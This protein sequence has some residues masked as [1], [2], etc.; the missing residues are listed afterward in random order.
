MISFCHTKKMRFVGLGMY[1]I[2][3][4]KKM[5]G[6]FDRNKEILAS[7]LYV[8]CDDILGFLFSLECVFVF[9]LFVVVVLVF[10]CLVII[11]AWIYLGAFLVLLSP[12][13]INK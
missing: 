7:V 3:N 2:E 5:K 12:V 4:T 13:L 6:R 10:S 1:T 8:S 9:F 11:I